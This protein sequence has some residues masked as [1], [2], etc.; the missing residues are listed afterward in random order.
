M[1]HFFTHGKFQDLNPMKKIKG[2][3]TD[4]LRPSRA[5]IE[6]IMA[7]AAALSVLKTKTGNFNI[8]KN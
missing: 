8:L 6:F 7:Y 4:E 2:G 3:A 1:H 5:T